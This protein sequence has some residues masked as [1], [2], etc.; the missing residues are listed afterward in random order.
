MKKNIWLLIFMTGISFQSTVLCVDSLL[1]NLPLGKNAPKTD[2]D[3]EAFLLVSDVLNQCYQHMLENHPAIK[4]VWASVM[5]QVLGNMKEKAAEL[6][7][8][9]QEGK[10]ISNKDAQE[11]M[12]N[13]YS[14][15]GHADKFEPI[16]KSPEFQESIN[17]CTIKT[18]ENLA[19]QT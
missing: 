18:L 6:L 17:Q 3:K 7:K 9:V 1:A 14:V 10:Q 13:M 12:M 4:K 5:P 16:V 19:K 15:I 2:L 8:Q 11:F